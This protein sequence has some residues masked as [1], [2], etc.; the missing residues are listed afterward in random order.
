MGHPEC[1]TS[2]ECLSDHLRRRCPVVGILIPVMARAAARC[3]DS[4]IPPEVGRGAARRLHHHD[5][6]GPAPGRRRPEA[7]RALGHH[8]AGRERIEPGRLEQ[9]R[10]E[11]RPGPR[12]DDEVNVA[13][14]QHGGRP[15]VNRQVRPRWPDSTKRASKGRPPRS[16]RQR[17]RK[18]R[19]RLPPS[20]RPASPWTSP[21]A[22]AP[23]PDHQRQQG[24]SAARNTAP[25]PAAPSC[26][27]RVPDV[28]SRAITQHGQ[29]FRM[30]ERPLHRIGHRDQFG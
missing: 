22:S 25:A 18:A 23:V 12:G 5:L 17:L 16:Q 24:R 7:A 20:G 30:L 8:D 1:L 9:L 14:P 2:P 26:C 27:R 3:G 28:W 15:H 19:S 21:L 29:P 11:V 4:R 10:S 13:V 6:S